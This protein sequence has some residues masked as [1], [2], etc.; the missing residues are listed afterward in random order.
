M[1]GGAYFAHP[2]YGSDGEYNV[3]SLLTN[4]VNDNITVAD[5]ISFSLTK[6][7]TDTV[8]INDLFDRV[9]AFERSVADNVSFSDSLTKAIA[10]RVADS[11]DVSDDLVKAI[12]VN[13]DDD[14]VTVVDILSKAIGVNKNDDIS[15]E[16]F[17]SR[18]VDWARAIND[19]IDVTDAIGKAVQSSISDSI[20]VTDA[21]GKTIT[22]NKSD[23]VSVAIAINASRI[24]LRGIIVNESQKNRTI[25]DKTDDR[26]I[27]DET[28]N[29]SV[30]NAS[31][32][33]NVSTDDTSGTI[34]TESIRRTFN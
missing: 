32:D 26:T 29:R 17:F 16:D 22:L 33:R 9:V 34:S 5:A 11:I 19:N 24:V 12:G 6:G 1:Y 4:T 18:L 20:E 8:E 21:T 15:V 23:A 31:S 28:D 14:V 25:V 13:L 3:S 2:H 10:H 7:L 27:D 30:N